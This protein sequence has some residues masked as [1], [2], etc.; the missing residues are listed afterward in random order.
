MRSALPPLTCAYWI[1][2]LSKEE[3]VLENQT[4]LAAISFK[5]HIPMFER[6]EPLQQCFVSSPGACLLHKRV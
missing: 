3:P 4:K 6:L 2:T 5:I 1:R